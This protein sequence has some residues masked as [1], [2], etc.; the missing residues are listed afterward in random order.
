MPAQLRPAEEAAESDAQNL[1]S[2]SRDQLLISPSK[3]QIRVAM[4]AIGAILGASAA[5][6]GLRKLVAV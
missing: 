1:P 3:S 2:A 4:V 5:A 6:M